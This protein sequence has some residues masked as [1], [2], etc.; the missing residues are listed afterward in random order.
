MVHNLTLKGKYE[1]VEE[2]ESLQ[3]EAELKDSYGKKSF[4][5]MVAVTY[6]SKNQRYVQ[7]T[8][9]SKNPKAG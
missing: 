1:N 4:A 3:L 2:I 7:V 8:T 9:S 6:F 5:S